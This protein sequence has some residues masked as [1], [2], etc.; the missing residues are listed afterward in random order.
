M[1][2]DAHILYIGQAIN[3]QDRWLAHHKW[4]QLIKLGSTLKI[5]WLECS[6]KSLLTEIELAMIQHFKPKLNKLGLGKRSHPDYEQVSAYIRKET[7]RAVKLALLEDG[8]EDFSDLVE[9][10]LIQWLKRRAK[11]RT[12]DG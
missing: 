6:D 2:N 3:L 1:V 9:K 4:N 5:A 12:N 11:N 8:G 10:Q 7:H